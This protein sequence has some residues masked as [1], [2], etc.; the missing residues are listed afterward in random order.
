MGGPRA[1]RAY[2]QDFF[3]VTLDGHILP[4]AEIGQEFWPFA[5]QGILAGIFLGSFPSLSLSLPWPLMNDAFQHHFIIGR[6]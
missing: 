6:E 1:A 4:S 5:R 3:G 2:I